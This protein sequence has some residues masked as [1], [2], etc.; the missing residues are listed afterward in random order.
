MTAFTEDVNMELVLFGYPQ[1]CV[2]RI[3]FSEIGGTALVHEQYS[4]YGMV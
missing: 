4:D 2:P 3:H 1:K